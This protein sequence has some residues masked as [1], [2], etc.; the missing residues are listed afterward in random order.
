MSDLDWFGT[1]TFADFS[2]S[3]V[4]LSSDWMKRK[5]LQLSAPLW[6][7]T[8]TWSPHSWAVRPWA[9][10]WLARSCKKVTVS[11]DGCH[12]V[13]CFHVLLIWQCSA[14]DFCNDY[15]TFIYCCTGRIRPTIGMDLDLFGSLDEVTLLGRTPISQ[16]R[17]G[18][19]YS[20]FAAETAWRLQ[21]ISSMRAG[22]TK[23]SGSLFVSDD[24][25]CF[26]GSSLT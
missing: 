5:A 13:T 2:A 21:T 1:L 19:V 25:S 24:P 26:C 16:P 3:S 17:R 4:F 18:V 23:S 9:T 11:L 12:R 10:K 14:N 7:V 15:S 8:W 6:Q 22:P 20:S